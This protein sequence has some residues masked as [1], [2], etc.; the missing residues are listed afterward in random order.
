M[1]AARMSGTGDPGYEEA[2]KKAADLDQQNLHRCQHCNRSFNE[3]AANRH[4]PICAKKAMAEQFKK[5]GKPAP[6]KSG[7]R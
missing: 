6:A 3:E 4:I 5:G 1:K 2:A 7:K